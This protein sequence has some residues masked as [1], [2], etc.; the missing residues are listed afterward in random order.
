M[1]WNLTPGET[2]K[3]TELHEL[4]GGSGQGGISPSTQSPNVM[5]FTDPTVGHQH[6]YFDGWA[7]DGLFHY[8]GE[9]QHGDQRM[10]G[11]NRA[12]LNAGTDGRKV[13]LIGGS[14]GVVT[15]LGEFSVD[16]QTPGIEQMPRSPGV[17]NCAK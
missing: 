7:E 5:A 13:R 2:I 3:R 14:G 10:K 8:T 15:Y 17:M 9:G 11:G 12:I 4:Y 6:G 16:T 1:A